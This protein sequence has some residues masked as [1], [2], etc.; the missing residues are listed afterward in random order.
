MKILKRITTGRYYRYEKERNRN[1]NRSEDSTD[2]SSVHPQ[3]DEAASGYELE[4][5]A[6]PVDGN[7]I[8]R[9]N[10]HPTLT[11]QGVNVL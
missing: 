8:E 2:E 6:A 7:L 4:Q 9:R 10:K 3:E 11:R 1:V 5:I